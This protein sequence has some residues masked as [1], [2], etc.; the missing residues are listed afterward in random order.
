MTSTPQDAF[1]P[2]H[3]AFAELLDSGL[4]YACALALAQYEL[5]ALLDDD[6]WAAMTDLQVRQGLYRVRAALDKA[7]RAEDDVKRIQQE[8]R[9]SAEADWLGLAARQLL[10]ARDR[11]LSGDRAGAKDCAAAALASIFSTKPTVR[12]EEADHQK[13]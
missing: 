6:V 2:A 4:P 10:T 3:E 7:R 11:L 5:V 1:G 13:R 9:D 12:W 8:G